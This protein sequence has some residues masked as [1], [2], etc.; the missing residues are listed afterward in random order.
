MKVKV[1]RNESCLQLENDVNE[2]LSRNGLGENIKDIQITSSTR[3]RAGVV[4]Y[5]IMVVM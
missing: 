3:S 5:I 2:F 4:E 1:F